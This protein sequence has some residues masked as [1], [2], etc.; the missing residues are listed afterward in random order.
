M[1]KLIYLFIGFFMAACSSDENEEVRETW[2]GQCWGI[3][4]GT[5]AIRPEYPECIIDLSKLPRKIQQAGDTLF[6]RAYS[7]TEFEA[8]Y[9]LVYYLNR[10]ELRVNESSTGDSTMVEAKKMVV[11]YEP[12]NYKEGRFDIEVLP[13]GV[14]CSVDGRRAKVCALVDYKTTSYSYGRE[15]TKHYDVKSDFTIEGNAEAIQ[16][17]NETHEYKV[18]MNDESCVLYQIRPIDNKIEME[19]Q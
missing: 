16:F 11:T 17:A 8:Q 5:G 12:G 7:G 14:Y 15:F 6:F 4:A 3:E 18:R 10:S 19:K 2:L 9:R 13:D 1:K